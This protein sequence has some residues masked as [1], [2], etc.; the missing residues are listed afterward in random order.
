MIWNELECAIEA[1]TAVWKISDKTWWE[2][3]W[4]L[5]FHQY[6]FTFSTSCK[7]FVWDR[8]IKCKYTFILC[9]YAIIYEI[10]LNPS[11]DDV[12]NFVVNL[13]CHPSS[14]GLVTELCVYVWQPYFN[15]YGHN[16]V[17]HRSIIPERIIFLYPTFSCC[18]PRSSAVW[19][20]PP[21]LPF[22]TIQHSFSDVQRKWWIKVSLYYRNGMRWLGIY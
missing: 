11:A 19:Y 1:C 18:C 21:K 17:K 2:C 7:Q 16:T 8:S 20:R 12:Q 3:C 14:W 15:P 5:L 10:L 4:E 9:N 13:K 6:C 22:S